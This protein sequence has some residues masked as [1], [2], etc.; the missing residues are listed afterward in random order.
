MDTLKC[1]LS[2]VSFLLLF[3]LIQGGTKAQTYDTISNWDGI[4]REW[5]ISTGTGGYAGNPLPD[6]V[7]NSE[8]CFRVVTGTGLYDF[9]ICDLDGPVNFDKNPRYRIK[10]L[11][12]SSGGH[13][14]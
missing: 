9:M 1:V 7:N 8:G 3:A 6:A 4:A 12:P 14:V 10:V 13:V 11:A 5:Y 2:R